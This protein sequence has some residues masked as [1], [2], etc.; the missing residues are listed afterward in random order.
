[1]SN[2]YDVIYDENQIS[3]NNEIEEVSNN[4]ENQEVSSYNENE[5]ICDKELNIS[6]INNHFD[7][8]TIYMTYKNEIPNF[9]MNRW[10]YLNSNYNIEF[11]LDKDCQDFLDKNFGSYFK[12]IFKFIKRG[13]FKADFWRICKLFIHSGVYA[14]VD[15]IPY[16]NIDSLYNDV[17]FYTCLATNKRSIFQAFMIIN[18][19]PT[20]PLLAACI[21]S[22]IK[23][24]PWDRPN[25]PT[26]DMYNVLLAA[27]GENSLQANKKYYVDTI[28]IPISIGNSI[29]NIKHIDL[30]WFP[31]N[32][33]YTLELENEGIWNDRFEFTIEEDT[34]IVKRIDAHSGWGAMHQVNVVIKCNECIYLF[35]EYQ[36]KNGTMTDAIVKNNNELIMDSRDKLYYKQGGW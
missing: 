31:K 24:E 7:N 34:L 36:P 1:M 30:N 23:N 19:P 12:F 8:K 27:T 29:H 5:I 33:D 4:Y 35:E 16:F 22:F 10:I 11:S 9:V 17:T 20:N 32:L 2:E 28:K 18:S 25:G 21:F 6:N 15:L 14:D 26:Y 3:T 13:M